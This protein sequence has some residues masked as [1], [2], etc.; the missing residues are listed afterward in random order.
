ME[1][2]KRERERK[3]KKKRKIYSVTKAK[4][5]SSTVVCIQMEE[6]KMSF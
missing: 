3:R 2:D 1:T 6:N 5:I 4:T